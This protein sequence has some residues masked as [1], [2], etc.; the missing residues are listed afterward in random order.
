MLTDPA[1]G[2]E[3]SSPTPDASDLVAIAGRL[4]HSVFRLA[5]VLRQQDDGGHPPAL[6]TALAVI[7][8]EGP[9]TLGDLA[10]QE[11]VSPPTITKVVDTLEARGFV[12]RIRD[13]HDRRVW[14]V[15]ATTRGRHQ[16]EASRS[17]RTEWL[18]RQLRDLPVDD[19]ARL[20]SALD[21]LEKLTAAPARE[22]R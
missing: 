11:Q 18:A 7:E 14:R 6:I 16:L 13:A 21:V 1:T 20:A 15:K 2:D 22:A 19:Y 5:R 4:R 17:R 9:L 3:V 8:R 12:E 10:T